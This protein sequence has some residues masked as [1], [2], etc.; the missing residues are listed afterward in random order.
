MPDVAKMQ[1]GRDVCRI[2]EENFRNRK[3]KTTKTRYR[4]GKSGPFKTKGS[5]ILKSINNP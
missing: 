2:D 1:Q 4:S 3:P 5:V